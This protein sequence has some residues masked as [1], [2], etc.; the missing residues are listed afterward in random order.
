MRELENIV[1]EI[2]RLRAC[3]TPSV[4]ATVVD[5][6][7]SAYRLPGAR[8]LVTDTEW[9]TGSVSG[10]CLESDV[11]ARAPDVIGNDAATVV[12]Y[13]TTSDDDIVF[14]VGLGCRGVI[15][16]LLEPVAAAPGPA[17][18]MNF[19]ENCLNQQQT[20]FAATLIGVEIG[21]ASCRE[22]V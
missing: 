2:R 8:M 22:R 6:A 3:G 11:V 12:T 10:G 20:G 17:D 13:D 9:I 4:L 18:F 16:V 7:G 14:G 19:A 1:K 5:V 21:R 15:R